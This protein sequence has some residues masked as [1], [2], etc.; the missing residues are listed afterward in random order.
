MTENKNKNLITA[1][2]FIFILLFLGW[3]LWI[4]NGIHWVDYD[5]AIN[6]PDLS[7][8]GTQVLSKGDS[9]EYSIIPEYHYIRA[10]GFVLINVADDGEGS[11]LIQ[12][13]DSDGKI[14]YNN[15][16]STGDI[17]VG[18]WHLAGIHQQ[19]KIGR[20]YTIS[21]SQE[22][23]TLE[24]YILTSDD[25]NCIITLYE[26]EASSWEKLCIFLVAL[27][28]C[29]LIFCT[30]TGIDI[31]SISN[32]SWSSVV[33]FMALLVQFV[34]CVPKMYYVLE[35][36]TLDPSWRY[37]LNVLGN[38]GYTMG[39]DLFFT[40][41]PLGYIVYLMN[42]A[43]NGSTYII[44]LIIH[45]LT[46]I[47]HMY[48]L[49]KVYV[50]YLRKK[51]SL[52]AIISSS[53]VYVAS[54]SR[55]EWDN[56]MLMVILLGVL[57]FKMYE[58]DRPSWITS[59]VIVNGMLLTMAFSKYSTFLSGVMFMMVFTIAERIFSKKWKSLYLFLPSVILM[60]ICYLIYCPSL[61]CLKEYF[62]QM[63]YIPMEYILSSQINKVFS[64]KDIFY[65]AVIILLFV[66]IIVIS[67]MYQ[68]KYATFLI[69]MSVSMFEA[70]KYAA[71]RHGLVP[72]IWLFSMLFAVTLFAV[73]WTLVFD[74]FKNTGKTIHKTAIIILA[75]CVCIPGI[76]SA[77]SIHYSA[78]QIKNDLSE[79]AYMLAH[80]NAPSIPEDLIEET[81]LS[82][83]VESILGDSSV[84]IY[85]WRQGLA[86]TNTWLNLQVFPSIQTCQLVGPKLDKADE[87]YFQSERAP[88]F[89]LL[90]D[91][92]VDERM[93]YFDSP[94]F[95]NS[96]VNNYNVRYLNGNECILE[97]VSDGNEKSLDEKIGEMK[98]LA[99]EKVDSDSII[100]RP[101][102]A[103]Y[104][105]VHI[106]YDLWAEIKLI[107][108]RVY[109][110]NIT[111][112]YSDG[113]SRTGRAIVKTLDEGFYLNYYP[114][115]NSE[116][117]TVLGTVDENGIMSENNTFSDI[118][119]ES[120]S[121]S[122]MGLQDMADQIEVEWYG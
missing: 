56:Y 63:I 82:D 93:A 30:L 61:S 23:M 110:S 107:I 42:I 43:D 20:E 115:N 99:K 67:I 5:Q 21:F 83:E 80:L 90:Y 94:H 53:L 44:G 6:Y 91:E 55:L 75:L 117:A 73:D 36:T 29:I 114:A 26:N 87:A 4:S 111:L 31:D 9:F 28:G 1:I 65:L 62:E 7:S 51:I 47:A 14:I 32:H 35:N 60:P 54:V 25:G 76:F 16:I 92:N 68:S 12:I 71:T 49:Y 45:M 50:L 85:P 88:K 33:A 95:W 58:D 81:R 101:E 86:A 96:I 98:F 10:V 118:T 59:A 2:P 121:F 17:P 41:G 27:L 84:A 119:I 112:N 39:K 8:A 102:G 109:V 77:N 19:V 37:L 18:E 105:K 108:N 122:G 15:S 103:K 38:K 70:Y 3:F 64:A 57:V 66:I 11:L 79:K 34:L 74:Q 72:G 46:I 104:V 113:T 116:L 97:K 106:D 120:F 40:Y 24:P 89:I 22:G 52:V 78:K 100:S 13:K 48:L 69:S